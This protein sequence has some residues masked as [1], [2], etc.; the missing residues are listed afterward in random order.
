M[1]TLFARLIFSATLITSTTTVFAQMNDEPP[2][3]FGPMQQ[4]LGPNEHD[5]LPP[6]ASFA[7][8]DDLVQLEHLYAMEGRLNE[9]EPVYRDVL[10]TSHDPMIRKFVRD[11]LVRY[12]L[13]PASIDQ[14]VATLK[15]NLTEDLA[16]A[17]R[18]CSPAAAKN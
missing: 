8:I 12:Q 13:R 5:H 4:R 16:F 6:G 1:K 14:A 17:D 10:A 9:I 11:A 3:P 7:A 18:S 2:P 15:S